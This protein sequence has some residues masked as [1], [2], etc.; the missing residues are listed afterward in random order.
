MKARVG[1]GVCLC[2]LK[3]EVLISLRN[4]S[5]PVFDSVICCLIVDKLFLG[6]FSVDISPLH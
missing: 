4:D 1:F 6:L 3:L 5:L 2:V